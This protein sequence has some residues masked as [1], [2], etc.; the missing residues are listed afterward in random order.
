MF[1]RRQTEAQHLQMLAGFRRSP[2][3]LRLKQMVPLL[4]RVTAVR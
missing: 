3:A 4:Q 1:A 2:F